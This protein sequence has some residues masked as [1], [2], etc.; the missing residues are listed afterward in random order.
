MSQKYYRLL[1]KKFKGINL[2]GKLSLLVV[3]GVFSAVSVLGCYFDSFLRETF[4]EEAKSRI[5]YGFQRLATD[6]KTTTEELK[7]GIFFIRTDEYFLASV[8]L[9]NNYQDK[10]NYNSA[11]L[12]EEK[13]IIA[14]Q[15]LNRVKLSLNHFMTLYD[16][17]EELIAFVDHCPDGYH[18]HFVSYQNGRKVLYSRHEDE[19]FFSK[20]P[21]PESES[22]PVNF[23]H[24]IYYSNEK[25]KQGTVTY[26]VHNG[27]VLATS[28]VSIFDEEQGSILMHLEMSHLFDE[29]Y[30]KKISNDLGLI[31]RYS[32][33]SKNVSSAHLLTTMNNVDDLHITQGKR[34]YFST[35]RLDIIGEEGYYDKS[36]FYYHIALNKEK[37]LITLAKNRHQFLLI[38]I[39]V[40]LL[41]LLILRTIFFKTLISPLDLL[42]EQIHKIEQQHYKQSASVQTGDELEEI[43]KNIKQ[44]AETVQDRERDLLLSQKE[45]EYL[46]LHDVLT[47][48]PNRRLF[49]QRLE[50]AIRK[51]RRHC[52]RLAVFFLDLDEFK[53][54]NDT[55]G[56]DVGDQL[57][58]KIASRLLGTQEFNPLITA[59]LGGD[60]FTVLLEDSNG[61]HDIAAAAEQVL[62]LFRTPFTCFDYELSTTVSIGIALFPDDGK[63]T[64]TLI[65]H[66]D[67]AMYRAKENGR[68]T[69]SFFSQG[70]A[71]T[72]KNRIDRM[73][74]LRKAVHDL[75]E[76]HLLYQP[77]ICLRTGRAKS[78]EALIRWQSPALGFVRPDQFIRLAE[79]ANLILPLGAW[80]IKQAFSDFM[81]F[82]ENGSP[83][84]K[85]C[86]NVSGIQLIRSDIVATIQEAMAGTGMRPEYIEL[87]ITEGSLAT[88]EKRALEALTRLREM[89]ID[90]AIDDFG[91]GY[92]SMSYLQQLPVTRLKIDKSFIDNL[93]D[94]EKNR[95]IV[96]TII[97]L[98]ETF[99]LHTTAE[100]VET[101]EQVKI[102]QQL[103]CNEIQGY[104]YAKPLSKEK[105]LTFSSTFTAKNIEYI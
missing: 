59:R 46:S 77:K 80:V 6:L 103:G 33:E 18:L 76:F 13:K 88:K 78:A 102:L 31:V 28:H 91:T 83:V 3:L 105:F 90:L 52:S 89:G 74:A 1:K 82:Q 44:L 55:L 70:L 51:A 72:V 63:D 39:V 87:E 5:L 67:M 84:K 10:K 50:Q 86:V 96:Q 8:E 17:N 98:A 2:T 65:K 34:A 75:D 94:S 36:S 11:L 54:V 22:L 16:K 85:M 37:L 56:H 53:Q 30:F 20:S 60:E 29:E 4:F 15:L 81:F 47:D 40:T 12:D 23:R 93:S 21:F 95:A 68:N 25:A 62:N 27:K 43:S 49:N 7:E 101:A 41:V 38:I 32:T 100:G 64:V 66:A 58:S 48:L 45:L 79:E 69:Y 57:L 24:R 42:M 73:N 26:Q 9:I 19:P 35:A 99:E 97:S 61:K 104:F 71:V 14:R 92:S